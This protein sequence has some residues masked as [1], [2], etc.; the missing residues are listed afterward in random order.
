MVVFKEILLRQVRI[1][2]IT[3]NIN[4][5]NYVEVKSGSTVRESICVLYGHVDI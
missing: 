2:T 5:L 4:A 1:N 3:D